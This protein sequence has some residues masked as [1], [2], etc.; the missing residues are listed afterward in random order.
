MTFAL[1]IQNLSLSTQ[2]VRSRVATARAV[3][4]RLSLLL[5]FSIAAS[6]VVAIGMIAIGSWV[7][8]RIEEGVVN[9]VA[10]VEDA[11]VENHIAPHLQELAQ[12]SDLNDEHKLAL[13]RLL[14]PMAASKPIV[15]FRIWKDNI[16][17]YGDRKEQIGKAYGETSALARARRGKT[18]VEFDQLSEEHS[19]AHPMQG[20]PVLEIY[21]PVRERGTNRIIAIAEINELATK[22]HQELTRA[23]RQ[24][25]FMVGTVTLAIIGCL[26]GIVHNGNRTIE[27]Q[28]HSLEQR[29]VELSLLLAENTD[30]RQRVDYANQRM[31]E[32]NERLLRRIGSDLHDGPV[33]LL[34]LALLKLQDFCDVIEDVDK[35]ILTKTDSVEVLRLALTETLQ[36]IRN[37]SAGLAPPDVENLT[38]RETLQMAAQKHEHRTGTRVECDVDGLDVIVP[39]PIKTCL[40]RFAQEGLNNAYR[41]AGGVGQALLVKFYPDAIEIGVSD[42]GPGMHIEQAVT[43]AGCQ[44]LSG[45]RFRVESLGGT[46]QIQSSLGCG[47]SLLVRFPLSRRELA[48]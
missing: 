20:E 39:F 6:I 40:Y 44:G 42:Q 7:S 21:A 10:T 45:L 23:Q 9:N 38:I 16:V 33:Q 25:W 18:V 8:G 17:V 29:V 2:F 13:D 28:R 31:A 27:R 34:G 5:Q 19:A 14:T 11:Y 12:Y 24:S 47:T 22:L 41:H 43:N 15:A 46:F 35:E 3:W 26:F 37:L 4:A 32:A 30:L 36:E 48:I 1:P